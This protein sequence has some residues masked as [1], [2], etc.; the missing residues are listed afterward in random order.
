MSHNTAEMPNR[1][2]ASG[3]GD[4][5]PH[6]LERSTPNTASPRPAAES[7]TPSRSM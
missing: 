2:G 4:T 6:V 5:H 1:S 7:T 3:L